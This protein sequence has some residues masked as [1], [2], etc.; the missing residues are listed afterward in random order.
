MPLW[1]AL[2][3]D[4]RVYAFTPEQLRLHWERLHLRDQEP[5]PEDVAVQQVWA[6]CHAGQFEQAV[7]LGLALGGAALTPAHWALLLHATYL[8]P[9]EKRRQAL[10][11]EVA[12]RC[13]DQLATDP[14]LASAH[15]LRAHALGR[16]AQGITVPKAVATGLGREVKKGL[17]RCLRLQPR[18]ADAHIALGT[19]HAE[20]IDKMGRMLGLAQGAD[21]NVGLW[22]FREALRIHPGSVLARM[23]YANGLVMLEGP[24]RLPDAER[25]YAEAASLTPLDAIEHLEVLRAR[26]ELDKD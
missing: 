10:W 1:T 11:Q 13:A 12:Q 23:G 4:T 3:A 25:L 9:H 26:T 19:F 15:Y 17:E 5:W 14:D 7:A 18:H 22:M 8:E 6:L 16:Y 20:L 2:P 24:R 21:T